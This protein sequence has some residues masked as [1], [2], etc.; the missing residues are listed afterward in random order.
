[1]EKV[2]MSS[3]SL[4]EWAKEHVADRISNKEESHQVKHWISSHD[5]LESPP[6][7]EF[8]IVSSFKDPLTRQLSEAIRIERR[9][10]SILNSK[11][12]FNRCRIPRL[13]IDLEAW[14]SKKK[15][16]DPAT[17]M[18]EVIMSSQQW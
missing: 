9:G 8:K 5:D 15:E 7:F 10:D 14:K 16:L 18:E 12:E 2:F 6:K 13:V 11:A 4:Y 17:N 3:R 1:M